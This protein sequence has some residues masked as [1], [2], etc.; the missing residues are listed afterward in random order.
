MTTADLEIQN[1]LKIQ[2]DLAIQKLKCLTRRFSLK[3]G[4]ASDLF[5]DIV[6]L[7]N[8]I[9]M[10]NKEILPP[11]P[12]IPPPPPPPPPPIAG[13]AGV[14]DVSPARTHGAHDLQVWESTSGKLTFSFDLQKPFYLP[15]RFGRLLIFLA[16]EAGE[17]NSLGGL[18]GYRTR[19]E[20][21]THLQK[22]AKPGK[23]IR[24]QYVNNVTNRLKAAI[25][26]HTGRDL[27]KTN[28]EL[29]VRVLLKI[30]GL[31]GLEAT[32]AHKWL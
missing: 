31:H 29:G 20:I 8:Q 2:I 22:T 10:M 1:D 14:S 12:P 11:I 28:N 13:A 9:N 32:T 27:I 25:L 15:T 24:R 17:D 16:T 23:Q 30:G 19:S 4:Q 5:S 26:E 18:L 7:V 3:Q 21:Q 6:D